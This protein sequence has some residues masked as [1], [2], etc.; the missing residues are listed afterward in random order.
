[1]TTYIQNRKARF[2]YELREEFEAG[3][4][5]FG[6]EVKAIRAGKGKL[7]GAHVVV[8]GGEAF[9]VGAHVSPFQ[10]ANTPP[11]YDPE[12]ARKLLFSRKELAHLE[13]ES[14]QAGLTIVPIKWYNSARNVKLLVALA[15]GK[16]KA[17][18]RESIK[19]R[20][21][22]RAIDRILKSQ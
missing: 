16:K 4:V 5:L 8:R 11:D 6:C 3:A 13:R 9:L 19:E 2:D 22:K 21:S 15:R 17:D 20:D 7:E 1:M 18:K 12:R 10:V 14:E